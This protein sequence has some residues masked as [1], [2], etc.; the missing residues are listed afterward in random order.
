MSMDQTEHFH[1]IS[2]FPLLTEKRP[3]LHTKKASTAGT[4]IGPCP[5]PDLR[6]EDETWR[7]SFAQKKILYGDFGRILP[8]G[9]ADQ[10]A[11]LK[12]TDDKRVPAVRMDKDIEPVTYNGLH[13]EVVE[14][15]VHQIGGKNVRA[16]IDLTATEPTMAMLALEWR[17]P[18]LGVTFNMEHQEM[19]KTR[20]AQLLFQQFRNVKSSMHIPKLVELLQGTPSAA[21]AAQGGNGDA[22]KRQAPKIVAQAGAEKSSGAAQAGNSSAL[23]AA[24][25][26][27]LSKDAGEAEVTAE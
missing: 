16:I 9:R 20:L 14:E 13:R 23:R 19:I 12:G 24:L 2:K 11:D 18:Y 4:C 3:R 17:I 10:D 5:L 7:I 25:V 22:G 8:G 1:F 15:M 27:Q 26:S 6:R 21:N